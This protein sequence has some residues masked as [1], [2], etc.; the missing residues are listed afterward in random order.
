MR[1]VGSVQSILTRCDSIVELVRSTWPFTEP[2]SRLFLTKW[3][4]VK[5][6][7]CT[8]LRKARVSLGD[9]IQLS[10]KNAV[11]KIAVS[12]LA[13]AVSACGGGEISDV[14]LLGDDV[15]LPGNASPV[16]SGSPPAQVTPGDAYAFQP[17]ASDPDG[18]N[19]SFS[20]VNKPAWAS[21]SATTGELSGTPDQADIG[22]TAGVRISASDGQ[23][24]S[25]L[26]IF[27]VTVTVSA[28]GSVTLNWVRPTENSD[29]SALTDLAGYS[30]YY[31]TSQS[32][33]NNTISISDP[34]VTSYTIGNLSPNT[35]F[36]VLT[37][38]NI[39]GVESDPSN[40]Q[41]DV[42]G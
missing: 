36:F 25:S 6:R 32:T 12:L 2:N 39:M 42:V 27:T 29:G 1:L 24:T 30:I 22:T 28:S 23:A 13:I 31:G 4:A 38:V 9:I 33:L 15:S 3:P 16:I 19:L 20:I 17:S 5:R 11:H 41:A 7:P 18:D 10:R 34:N 35:Y 21:F 40:I 14:S 8:G 26:P 37:A